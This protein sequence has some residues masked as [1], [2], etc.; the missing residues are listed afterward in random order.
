MKIGY[1]VSEFPAISHAF[2]SREIEAV[3]AAGIEVVAASVRRPSRP[4]VLS[5][6]DRRDMDVVCYLKPGLAVHGPL[7]LAGLCL[8]APLATMRMIRLAWRFDRQGAR[9]LPHAAA[10]VLEAARLIGWARRE[11]IGHVHVHFG[12]PAALVA[13]LAA[14]TGA[15]TYSLSIHGPDD[16]YELAV[17][18]LDEKCR[19]AVFVRAISHFCRSQIL[20]LL[21]AEQWDKVSIVH[22][23]VSVEAFQPAPI[24]PTEDGSFRLLCTGRLCINKAQAILLRALRLL[25]DRGIPARLD[26]VGDGPSADDLRALAGSLGLSDRV[27]FAGAVGRDRVGTFVRRCDVFVL[28][29]FAEGV[30]VV[31]MEAMAMARPVVSTLIAGIPELIR[32]GVSGV[33]VAPG[34]ESALADALEQLYRDPERRATLARGGREAVVAGFQQEACGRQMAAL[35]GRFLRP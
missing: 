21:P 19:R 2:I 20:R 10:Y 34:D 14:E 1:L 12:N 5:P 25:V 8:R 29:S 7:A 31:L 16:F 32:D 30:P 33:L 24:E 11:K 22:C 3:R 23:G 4:D 28:P 6:E 13:C 17:N 9:R 35:F 15:L 18:V 27:V 26:L